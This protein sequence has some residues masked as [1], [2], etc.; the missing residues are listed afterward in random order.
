MKER[1]SVVVRNSILQQSKWGVY[2]VP[3]AQPEFELMDSCGYASRDEA[4]SVARNVS[5]KYRNMRLIIAEDIIVDE[6]PRQPHGAY[7]RVIGDEGTIKGYLETYL[8]DIFD[9]IDKL[10]VSKMKLNPKELLAALVSSPAPLAVIGILVYYF[11][12]EVKAP[13]WI[14]SVLPTGMTNS[15][16]FI[17]AIPFL[18]CISAIHS[19][20]LLGSIGYQMDAL[21]NYLL[22]LIFKYGWR[23]EQIL[24]PFVKELGKIEHSAISHFA[25]S[26]L[27]H[28]PDAYRNIMSSGGEQGD[29]KVQEFHDLY[30]LLLANDFERRVHALLFLEKERWYKPKRISFNP[31][32]FLVAYESRNLQFQIIKNVATRGGTSGDIAA[33]SRQAAAFRTVMYYLGALITFIILYGLIGFALYLGIFEAARLSLNWRVAASVCAFIALAIPFYRFYRVY[34]KCYGRPRG[35]YIWE[36]GPITT[37]TLA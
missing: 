21:R 20:F 2:L 35:F 10:R 36:I 32:N 9:Q 3:I 14:L 8:K 12:F 34:V 24:E 37:C 7:E 5:K 29:S 28:D 16:Q 30:K 11:G 19:V 22:V 6:S 1:Y 4:S 18:M 25:D 15:S 27:N 13:D 23:L 17:I 31:W 33:A 26:L